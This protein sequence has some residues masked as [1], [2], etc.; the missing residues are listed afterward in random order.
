MIK[1]EKPCLN[2]NDPKIFPEPGN[3]DKCQIPMAECSYWWMVIPV[4]LEVFMG[5]YDILPKG[6][7]VKLWDCKMATK[8]KGD[9]VPSFDLSEY[10]VL[11]REGGYVRV[12]CGI[13]TEIKE[14]SNINFYPEDFPNISCFDKWG[15]EV[16]YHDDLIG[17]FQ[18]I[19][20]VDDSYYYKSN[21]VSNQD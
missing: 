16:D 21:G 12:N 4:G 11:L 13:I 5:I 14:N 6:S 18:G 2:W 8:K 17:Q 19:A 3:C 7:Q 10:I 1:I 9:S 20:G 15:C